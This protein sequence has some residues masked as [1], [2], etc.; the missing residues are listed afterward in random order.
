M[1]NVSTRNVQSAYHR[2][3]PMVRTF[4]Q[5]V[6]TR[7]GLALALPA[8]VFVEFRNP[9]E[10]VLFDKDRNANPFFHLVE[11]L[12][13]LAGRNDTAFVRQFNQNMM[14]YSDDGLT[15]NAAYG[16]RWRQH[17][18]YDQI[19][20][21]CEILGRNPL[22]R[23]SV[24]SMWDGY[25]DLGGTGLDYPCNTSIMCRIVEGKL[26]FTITNRSNDLVFGLCGANAV[27]MSILQEYMAARLGVKVGFWYQLTN[28]LHV[29][30]RH[31]PL[32]EGKF[33]GS[34][35]WSPYPKPQPLVQDYKAFDQ[36]CIDLCNGKVDYF[37]E[38]FF[39]GTV[40]PLVQSWHAYKQGDSDEALH[41]ASCIEA[42]D[43]RKASMDW[44]T[45]AVE[46]RHASQ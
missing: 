16:H 30:E 8:P 7:N 40:A 20:T 35:E 45:R 27:H 15:F 33:S 38:P 23:R 17:F 14:T 44:I 41:L 19:S 28:N 43:W 1:Y 39:D 12:W 24:L 31:F 42:D 46:K 37:A 4:G 5:G 3:M 36:D 25:N 10:R 32:L 21:V 6:E 2:L 18:G 34:W 22:D 26:D 9:V 13:M 29:Y 11:A